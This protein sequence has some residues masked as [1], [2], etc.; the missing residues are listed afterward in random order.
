VSLKANR[1]PEGGGQH[2]IIANAP[3]GVKETK[4]GNEGKSVV[5]LIAPANSVSTSVLGGLFGV[6]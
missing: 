1:R 4:A 2:R 3:A 5:R 6:K